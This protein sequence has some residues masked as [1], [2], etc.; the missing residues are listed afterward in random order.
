MEPEFIKWPRMQRLFKLPM[1]ITEKIDGTNACVVFGDDGDVFVQSRNRIITPD[2]D[3]YG[4]ATWVYDNSEE[5]FY[6]LGPGRHYGEWWG[7]GIQRGYGMDHRVFSLF[8][9]ERWYK[10]S[11]DGLDSM[12]TRAGLSGLHEEIDVVPALAHETFSEEVIRD[13]A[14]FLYT[15][16]S[17]ASHRQGVDEMQPAEGICIFLPAIGTS[18][19]YT[20]DGNDS[21]KWEESNELP[22]F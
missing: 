3:N 2:S 7:K 21:H 15:Q 11:A 20:F 16:G 19:K 22:V 5:L 1:V 10:T 9:V 4:F 12:S 14:R 13:Q 6:I 8:N 17:W 18:F